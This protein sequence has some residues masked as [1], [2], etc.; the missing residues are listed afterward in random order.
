M[1]NRAWHAWTATRSN[2]LKSPQ[3]RGLDKSAVL[4]AAEQR[5]EVTSDAPVV[6][7]I[8]AKHWS[9]QIPACISLRVD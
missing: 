6:V 4:K 7:R 3:I 9:G 5:Q 8:E 1:E 2:R